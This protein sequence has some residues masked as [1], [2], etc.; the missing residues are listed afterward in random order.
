MERA[1]VDEE[2]AQRPST[3]ATSPGEGSNLYSLRYRPSTLTYLCCTVS[4]STRLKH[5]FV[6]YL[7]E[8]L[9]M[10][11]KSVNLNLRR[12]YSWY[13]MQQMIEGLRSAAMHR[14]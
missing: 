14:G 6:N 9:I 13:D 10:Y 8:A 12:L 1:I 2:L 5:K 11:S 7:R 3:L 4:V